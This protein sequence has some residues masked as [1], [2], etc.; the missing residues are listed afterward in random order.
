MSRAVH[1]VYRQSKGPQ[2]LSAQEI[3]EINKLPVQY[4][5]TLP[6]FRQ[7]DNSPQVMFKAH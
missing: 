4:L 1:F 3:K 2:I 7:L 5:S 6:Y